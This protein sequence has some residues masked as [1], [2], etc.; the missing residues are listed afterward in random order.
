MRVKLAV[1]GGTFD[2]LH[3]GH[4]ELLA[5]AFE[6]ADVIAIGVTTDRFLARHP[7]PL[8]RSIASYASRRRHLVDYLRRHYP[9]SRWRIVPLE[10]GWGRSVEA[11]P[12]MLVASEDTRAGALSVNRER[13]RRGLPP[14]RLHIIPL[15]RAEDGT[16]ISSR[17]I[18]A[19]VID[20]AGRR[21]LP[22]RVAYIGP[23][24]W[25]RAVQQA[26]ET[27]YPNLAVGLGTPGASDDL[28]IRIGTGSAARTVTLV[29][30]PDLDRTAR[31]R[32]P[33]DA[34]HVA[35]A[36]ARLVR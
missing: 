10:D 19:R 13:R 31:I 6:Q 35:Q 5:A 20:A 22:L 25:R 4:E 23:A 34:G 2:H 27:R 24:R 3:A 32:A 1:L 8:P 12:E 26:L 16:S 36:L 14:L 18:R 17:R 30:P 29:R 21:L 33:V 7:K 28:T 9:P 11:G 15:R